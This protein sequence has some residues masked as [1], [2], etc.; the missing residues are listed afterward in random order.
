MME[1][2]VIVL[3]LTLSELLFSVVFRHL[4]LER[5]VFT[6]EGRQARKGLSPTASDSDQE[7]IP[8]WLSNHPD[9]L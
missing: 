4:N 9:Y 8:T 2:M 7:H 6:Y 1:K 3:A 5:R